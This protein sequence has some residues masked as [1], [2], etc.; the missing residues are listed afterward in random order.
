MMNIADLIILLVVAALVILAVVRMARRRKSSGTFCEHCCGGCAM[1]GE[2]HKSMQ[3][4]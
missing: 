1:S 2:C 3:N 4:K